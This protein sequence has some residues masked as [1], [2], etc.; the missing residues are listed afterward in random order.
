MFLFDSLKRHAA[1]F[2]AVATV[3]L[4]VA[5]A[6]P[7]H[8]GPAVWVVKDADSTIYLLGTVH[9]LKPDTQWRSA[10]IDKALKDSADLWLEVEA[11]DPAVMQPLIL[12]YGLDQAHPLSTKLS[13][14]EFARLD[15]AA[16]GM[17]A[18]GAA[19]EPMR[20]W[21]AGVTLSVAPLLKAGYDP[22]SGVEAKLKAEAKAAGKPIRTLETAE[23]QIRF[24][25]DMSPAMELTFLRSSLDDATD[26]PA[27]L[28]EMVAAWA[29]GDVAGI[30]RLMIAE[31]RA[32]YPALYE[33]L[34]VRRNADWAQ[35]IDTLLKSKGVTIIAVGAGHLAGDESVQAQLAKRGIKAERLKD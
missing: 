2:A 19:L 27:L 23:Q 20:P 18:S 26:A 7:A 13:P 1:A 9:F 14:E 22:N 24:F 10:N 17:G 16:R 25:A 15:A 8:A 3:A 12:K 32:D 35:Q 11:D 5:C 6:P 30:D 21:L 31:M 29:G 28:D 4:G 33:L 34:L